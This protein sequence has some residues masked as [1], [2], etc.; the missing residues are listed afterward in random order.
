MADMET[1]ALTALRHELDADRPRHARA[2]LSAAARARAIERGILGLYRW[3]TAH[4]QR[5]RN[6]H[7][8]T[9]V[10]WRTVRRDH[11]DAISTIV[12]GF[13]AVEQYTPDYVAPLLGLIRESYGRSQWH[14]RWGAEE[15][16]HSDLWGN[17]VAA[18]GR[19]SPA[20]MEN[21]AG[22][23]RKH[24]WRLP[25]DSARHIVFY[26]V[27]Q[28]RATQVSYLNLALAASG[29]LPRLQ[30]PADDTLAAA[31]RLI[32]ADEAAHYSFFVEVARLL[33]YY[34]PEASVEALVDV[35][36]HFAMP[37]RDL[38][39]GY[40]EFGRILHDTGVFGRVIHYR[41]VVR[42]VLDALSAPALRELEAGVRRSREI[43]ATDG[44]RR[45]AA[46][47]D[48]LNHAELQTK[49]SRVFARNAAHLARVGLD[50]PAHTP[51][52]AAWAFEQEPAA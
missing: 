10:D 36:R 30:T 11:C 17:C 39:P 7:A 48:T 52:E 42:V 45:T 21:Y 20:W 44:S 4:S 12:E 15:V 51:F 32:G 38:I 40:D 35:L 27:I 23:L 14:V 25:W 29:R 3:Y 41:D 37:A 28:E 50:H 47:L 49:V 5:C 33:L 22:E 24:E 8:D 6:W 19:R 13:F 26:Q 46:L 18:F 16:R 34:E 1:G 31:C 43:P 2:L 9:C